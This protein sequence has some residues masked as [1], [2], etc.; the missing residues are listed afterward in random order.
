MNWNWKSIKKLDCFLHMVTNTLQNP[1][2]DK[3]F[4]V[5]LEFNIYFC[6]L[7]CVKTTITHYSC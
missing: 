7:V 4:A 2:V 3:T 1:S 6:F 5:Y